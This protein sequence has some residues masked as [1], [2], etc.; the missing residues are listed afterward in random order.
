MKIVSE[1]KEIK[2]LCKS[3]KK[4]EKTIALVPT[5]GFL[6]AGHISL[7]KKAREKADIVIVSRF[8]NPTQ[9]APNE[10]LDAYPN[11]RERDH[12]ATSEAG[13]DILFEPL[14]TAMYNENHGTWVEVPELGK[15][16]CGQTRPI[17]FRGVC[18][19]VTK[20]F[21]LIQPDFAVFGAKDYQQLTIIRRMVRDLN[22]DVEI[23][24]GDIIREDDGLAMSSRNAYLT[25]EERSLAPFIRKGLLLLAE[26]AKNGE[27][28]AN[29]LYTIFSQF[30]QEHIPQARIDYVKMVDKDELL[31]L[32]N[33]K[34]SAVIAVAV[35]LGKARLIDNILI[36][37]K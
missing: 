16:L 15:L 32:E 7:I 28:N 35:Y 14:A 34:D 26:K 12:K 4:Q 31:E 20:L 36:E 23:I 13:T 29:S 27:H 8:V 2:E 1:L 18:T 30:I 24:A 5:M 3:L 25:K 19:V 6:H 11:D 21:N 10:D 33:L 9:F 17:H 22:I 37:S